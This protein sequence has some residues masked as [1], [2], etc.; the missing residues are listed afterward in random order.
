M[1]K[2]LGKRIFCHWNYWYYL[3]LSSSAQWSSVI[4]HKK[5][6]AWCIYCAGKL[7][8]D[9]RR[10]WY[11][12]WASLS[13]PLCLSHSGLLTGSLQWISLLCVC[14]LSHCSGRQTC[15]TPEATS[16]CLCVSVSLSHACAF[17]SSF[18]GQKF[19]RLQVECPETA[20]KVQFLNTSSPHCSSSTVGSPKHAG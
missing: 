2:I 6:P 8:V 3:L 5:K 17:R 11:K 14:L 16:V 1:N 9:W 4:T 19:L 18:F 10:T 15:Y 20:P 12:V 13:L 7:C